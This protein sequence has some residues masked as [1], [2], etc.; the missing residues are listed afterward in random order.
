MAKNNLTRRQV[1]KSIAVGAVGAATLPRMLIA[2]TGAKINFP[3]VLSRTPG[4]KPNFLFI[5]AE[6]TPLGA[7]GAYGSY[8]MK[9]PNIDRLATE[10]MKLENAC[11]TNALC[12][13][14]RATL[15]TGT[16]SNVNGMT[17]NAG[18]PPLGYD[19]DLFDGSQL[20][21][22]KVLRDH[23]YQTGIVGKWHLGSTPTGFD[24]WNITYEPAGPYYDHTWYE[25]PEKSGDE[26]KNPD[27]TKYGIKKLHKE[28]VT[29]LTTDLAIKFM[30]SAREPFC[31]IFSPI[32]VHGPFEPPDKY[33]HLYDNE[34]IV[35]PGTFWD[36]YSNRSAAAKEA[37]MRIEDM[38]NF[39]FP[40]H[41]AEHRPNDLTDKQRKEWNYQ[42][43]I[44]GFKGTMKSLDDNIGRM[45]HSLDE[46]GLRNDTIV[47]FTSDHG[48]FLGEHGWFDKRFMYEEAIRVPW[49]IRYPGEIK[50]G[51][52]ADAL[53]LNIDNAPTLLD[54]AGLPVPSV[55]Q[56]VSLRP[57]FEEKTT[58]DWQ[59]MMYYH[60]YPQGPPHFILPHYG[61]RTDRY[62]LINYYTINEWE[63]FDRKYDP[64]EMDSL[65]VMGG[66]KVDPNYEKTVPSLIGDLKKLREKYKDSTGSKV[67]FWPTSMYD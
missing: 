67:R 45:M 10:G 35:E 8:R 26:E 53:A 58:S 50:A 54:L 13:P 14:S 51:S 37:H 5:L 2:E 59:T 41:V 34:R 46:S 1:I 19:T 3:N 39:Q 61:I 29:D 65:F 63:L 7:I 48:L 30:K 31:L 33:K 32:A 52:T 11:V 9:T 66:Y 25:K 12:S 44:K 49:I 16:Y 22:P 36:D 56:G 17:G 38:G 40:D 55:M 47:I 42:T 23:G 24:Y 4:K 60:Y 18:V 62:S 15:L 20:T 28:Y 6:G 57:I 64:D 21:F 27:Y 43:F